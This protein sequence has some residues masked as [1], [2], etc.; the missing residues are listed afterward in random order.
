M[1][2]RNLT[3]NAEG[4]ALLSRRNEVSCEE[5]QAPCV[6]PPV[7]SQKLTSEEGVRNAA[8]D[9]KQS[10]RSPACILR[11]PAQAAPGS[12]RTTGVMLGTW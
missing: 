2:I 7:K 5:S 10:V 6:M 12:R 9:C 11:A 4:L 3:G 1:R 8:F